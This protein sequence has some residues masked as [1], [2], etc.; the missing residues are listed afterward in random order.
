MRKLLNL[1]NFS[2]QN[3]ETSHDLCLVR[4]KAENGEEFITAANLLNKDLEKVSIEFHNYEDNKKDKNKIL[5]E[6]LSIPSRSALQWS[7]NK[8]ITDF[9]KIIICTSEINKIQKILRV[10]PSECNIKGFHFKKSKNFMQLEFSKKPQNIILG[11]KKISEKKLKEDNNLGIK[12]EDKTISKGIKKYY[13]SVWYSG[14]FKL[15]LSFSEKKKKSESVFFEF[16][17][18]D[19]FSNE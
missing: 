8:N 11:D 2:N 7:K 13:L 14:N 18:I 17:E 1:L 6:D 12:L 16:L 10:Q 15:K 9:L 4:Q 19:N 3:T 5:I